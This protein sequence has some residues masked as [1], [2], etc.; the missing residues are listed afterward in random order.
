MQVAILTRQLLKLQPKK[1]SNLEERVSALENDIEGLL[2]R[3]QSINFLSL[4]SEDIA[5]L[6]LNGKD[7]LV[8][9]IYPKDAAKVLAEAG[10]ASV[11]IKVITDKTKALVNDAFLT[12][13]STGFEDGYFY[14]VTNA[15]G[16]DLD[17]I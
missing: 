12:I 1:I 8:F 11:A 15:Q 6:S 10:P 9:D 13:Q 16:M 3:I 4:N 2:A 7:T 5:R 17:I 14:I